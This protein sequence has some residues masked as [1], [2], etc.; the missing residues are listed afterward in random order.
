VTVRWKNI[1]FALPGNDFAHRPPTRGQGGVPPILLA[2]EI[3]AIFFPIY[4]EIKT[5]SKK[6]FKNLGFFLQYFWF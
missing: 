1:S 5:I 2:S 4:T 3:L 6:K